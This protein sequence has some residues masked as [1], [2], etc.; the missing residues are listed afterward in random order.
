MNY[1]KDIKEVR[2]SAIRNYKDY[3][4]ERRSPEHNETIHFAAGI[5]Q[6]VEQAGEEFMFVFGDSWKSVTICLVVRTMSSA[7]RILSEI[8]KKY[9][10][11]S[12]TVSKTDTQD[13]YCYNVP[14]FD[15]NYVELRISP[16]ECKLIQ[17][18]YEKVPKFKRVCDES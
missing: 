18:G 10:C 15:F 11:N 16:K 7:A 4:Q 1:L 6:S 5:M 13:V 9:V 12:A 2:D 17:D 14:G 8:N 3:I